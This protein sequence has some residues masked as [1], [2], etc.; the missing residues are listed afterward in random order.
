MPGAT[1]GDVHTGIGHPGSGQT[2]SEI[3]HEGKPKR[4]RDATG[5]EGTGASGGT[6]LQ[7]N[8]DLSTEARRLQEEHPQRGPKAAQEHNTSL[9][10]AEGKTP[11]GADEVAAE[12][13]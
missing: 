10:G 11:I 13:D 3:R 1:S 8:D 5:L 4:E 9:T 7:G 12:R 2:S 6:G